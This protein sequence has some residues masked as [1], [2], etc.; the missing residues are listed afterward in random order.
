MNKDAKIGL[1]AILA[2]V[3]LLVI[4]WGR[5]TFWNKDEEEVS[6]V[7]AAPRTDLV[8]DPGVASVDTAWRSAA[9][10]TPVVGQSNPVRDRVEDVAGPITTLPD[11][12]VVPPQAAVQRSPAPGA[13]IG[14]MPAV[15]GVAGTTYVVQRGDTLSAIAKKFYGD[16]SQ[17]RLIATANRI[18]NPNALVIGMKL[19]IPPQEG[20]PAEAPA[21]PTA[22]P[23][24]VV[25]D[26][27]ATYVVQKG[28]TLTAIA[29]KVYK[30]G[31]KWRLIA[32]ANRTADPNR[33]QVGQK[34]VV[35]LL[36]S[37]ASQAPTSGGSANSVPR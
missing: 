30:D 33:L 37:A 29:Q 4:F 9:N 26:G 19:S 17:W 35:P 27:S 6:G 13:A 8:G 20:V 5:S 16:E 24:A 28:D 3:V 32:E 12:T 34:L 21:A 11:G 25:T 2:L 36:P 31:S 15:A 1:I 14:T 10:S 22:P 7:P 23:D 18:S